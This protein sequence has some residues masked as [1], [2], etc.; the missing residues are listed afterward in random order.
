MA[1]RAD[2]EDFT[3]RP[4]RLLHRLDHP[5]VSRR[6][7]PDLGQ[8]ERTV[9]AHTSDA[10]IADARVRADSLGDRRSDRGRNTYKVASTA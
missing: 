8:V 9:H 5:L 7:Q 6:L 2:V 3:G 10:A 4:Y 1:Q